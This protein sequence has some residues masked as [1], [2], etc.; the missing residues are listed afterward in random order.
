MFD[1]IHENAL[2][3]EANFRIIKQNH[4]KG[5]F[6]ISKEG[7]ECFPRYGCRTIQINSKMISWKEEEKYE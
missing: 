6:R 1:F 5:I 2:K 7:T 4:E 3:R